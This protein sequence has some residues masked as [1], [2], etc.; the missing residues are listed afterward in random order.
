M[1]AGGPEAFSILGGDADK[2]M[3]EQNQ[4]KPLDSI[5]LTA[6]YSLHSPESLREW[7]PQKT[8]RKRRPGSPQCGGF[9]SPSPTSRQDS[10]QVNHVLGPLLLPVLSTSGTFHM[11]W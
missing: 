5:F 3:C 4:N 8:S 2:T 1:P 6:K 10:A 7:T 9:F 11:A